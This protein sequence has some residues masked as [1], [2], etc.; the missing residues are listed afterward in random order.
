MYHAFGSVSMAVMDNSVPKNDYQVRSSWVIEHPVRDRFDVTVVAM[1]YS[2]LGLN[3]NIANHHAPF[4]RLYANNKAGADI[5]FRDSWIPLEPGILYLIPAWVSFSSRASGA[6]GHAFAHLDIRGIS[7][8]MIRTL[9]AEPLALPA[10]RSQAQELEDLGRVLT[11]DEP[12]PLDRVLRIRA[13]ADHA[14]AMAIA[15]LSTEQ[16]K[17]LSPQSLRG[18]LA[19]V[20]AYLHANPTAPA[21]NRDLARI[22]DC[23]PDHLVRSFRREL[24]QTPA[25]Y[26]L[27]LRL[28]AAAQALAHEDLS[29]DIIA[30]EYGFANRYSFTRAFTRY[31]GCGPGEWRRRQ[32]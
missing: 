15:G 14:L 2:D 27:E 28:T 32:R 13:V 22:I 11:W 18:P 25:R 29:I 21:S 31:L 9:F 8:P 24:G 17:K 23:T 20:L 30:Q 16:R 26:V 10:A 7:G 4:W 3:W 6:V 19:S 12:P 5:R 1:G